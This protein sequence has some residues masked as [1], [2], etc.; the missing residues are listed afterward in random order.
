MTHTT[1]PLREN[2]YDGCCMRC[3]TNV[4][5]K[6]G[7]IFR[8]DGAWWVIH[9]E[10]QCPVPAP[11]AAAPTHIAPEG[12]EDVVVEYQP[13][14]YTVAGETG[15]HTFKVMLQPSDHKFAPGATIIEYLCGRDNTNDYKG[16][17][18]IR[19]GKLIPWKKFRG[20]GSKDL[21][22]AAQVLLDGG[23]HVIESVNCLRCGRVL[24][25]PE[26]VDAGIG[27]ECRRLGLR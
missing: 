9:P 23:E 4:P 18:F 21:V 22:V 19:K 10:G 16:F 11:E 8:R 26:S 20:E 17:A 27:P 1:A 25:T 13:G 7:Y 14:I 15:H 3:G 12:P 6:A 5:A 24:T 2:Q